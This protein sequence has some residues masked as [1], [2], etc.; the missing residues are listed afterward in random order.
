MRIAVVGAGV[1][2][3][4]A[5]RLLAT[6]HDVTLYEASD[7]LGGHAN[8]VDVTVDGRSFSVDTGFMVFNSRTYPTFQ[9]LLGLLNV[10]SQS[11]D[12]SFS[13][14]CERSGLEYQGSSLSGLFAQRTNLWRPKFWAMI[15]DIV[16]FNRQARKFLERNEHST[17]LDEFLSKRRYG[18]A[19][20]ENYLLPMT[21]AIWSSPMESVRSFPAHF[22][23]QFMQNHGLLQIRD[24]PDWQTI[25]GGSRHYV[26]ALAA[27]LEERVR[28]NT[29][30]QSVT[31]DVDQI[32]VETRDYGAESFEAVIMAVHA[33][34]ALKLLSVATDRELELLSSFQYQLNRAVLH[35]DENWLPSRK[36]A[37]ASWN[38]LIPTADS[39]Q[40]CVTY[41]L[42]RLQRINSPQ[43]ILL[44]LNPHRS[45]SE[46]HILKEF[47][48]SHPMFNAEAIA[49]QEGWANISGIQRTFFC[50][51]YWRNGFHEDGVVSALA[52]AGQFGIKLEAC[53]AVCTTE[54]SP[55]EEPVQ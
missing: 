35:T 12:M 15:A 38:Y 14:K 55:I 27:G 13:V 3:L 36:S 31:R 54:L 40:T 5:A 26:K 20:C 49:A 24:R 53:T 16:R 39:S 19:F 17:T 22:L 7:Y 25:P 32:H 10:K 23:L 47:T 33:D 51:A 37:W 44:T 52:V 18:R 29:P 1:S 4:L 30:V 11:S 46:L 21:A 34:T 42:T 48:Y 9:R 50:G 28:F 8:T 43:R 45:I 6:R 41:D 2:G